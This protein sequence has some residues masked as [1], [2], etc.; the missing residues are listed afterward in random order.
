[1]PDPIRLGVVGVGAVAQAVHLPLLERL[2]DHF[3]IAAVAD[4]SPKLVETVGE[5]HR[6]PS[7]GRFLALD[8]MLHEPDLDAVMILTSG[9]HGE[10]ILRS[11][12]ARLAVFT[13][14]PMA[15]T[16]GEADAISNA[17]AAHGSPALQVGYMKLYDPA[18]EQ[19]V[20]EV[21]RETA[22]SIRSIDVRVLHPSSRRQLAHARLLPPPGDVP[23]STLAA[24]EADA[25]RLYDEALGPAGPALGPLYADVVLGSI[26]HDLAVMRA[27]AGDPVSIDFADVWPE[28][29]SPGSVSIDGRLE[30]G[31]RF[32]IRWHYLPDH[33][34]YREEVRVVTDHASIEVEFPSPYLLNAPTVLRVGAACRRRSGRHVLPIRHRSVRA[35]AAG[36]SRPRGG[37]HPTASRRRGG[38]RRHRDVAAGR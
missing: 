17:L 8:D 24:F 30:G 5:R 1:M 2:P 33:P 7:T 27:I 28:G 25:A 37:R 12:S 20:V 18:V 9:S 32:A 36:L 15:W 31:T 19:A 6:V 35:G 11:L 38:S 21:G 13:E 22:G 29:S 23:A 14:K 26:V 4:V 34:A 16:L 10:A 3:R